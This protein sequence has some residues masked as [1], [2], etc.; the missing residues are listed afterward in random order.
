MATATLSKRT[1]VIKGAVVGSMAKINRYI[2]GC[3]PVPST[4]KVVGAKRGS[5][6]KGRSKTAD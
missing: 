4:H 1:R 5:N 3:K 6:G 2:G